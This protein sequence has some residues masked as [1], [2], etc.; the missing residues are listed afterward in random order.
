VSNR[1]NVRITQSAQER[2]STSVAPHEPS[3]AR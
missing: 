2:G 3:S 1:T